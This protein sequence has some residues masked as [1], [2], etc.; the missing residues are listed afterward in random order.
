[1]SYTGLVISGVNS[2]TKA[3]GISLGTDAVFLEVV[4][5]EETSC[6]SGIFSTSDTK[7]ASGGGRRGNKDVSRGVKLRLMFAKNEEISSVIS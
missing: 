4:R 2:L 6:S 3:I 5:R 1:M 7:W